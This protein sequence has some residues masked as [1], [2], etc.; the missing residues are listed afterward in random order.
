MQSTP[1]LEIDAWILDITVHHTGMLLWLKTRSGRTIRAIAPFK[2]SFYAV[3]H[4]YRSWKDKGKVNESYL[5]FIHSLKKNHLI[6]NV[7]IVSRR[8]KAEDVEES[9]VIQIMVDNPKNFKKVTKQVREMNSFTLYNADIPLAQMYLYE[10]ELFPMAFCRFKGKW[11]KNI[12]N[13]ESINLQDST[14]SIYYDLPQLKA[15]WI[16]IFS[17]SPHLERMHTDPIQEISISVDP[18]SQGIELSELFP[19]YVLNQSSSNQ[20]K[21]VL[22]EGNEYETLVSFS[23]AIEIIDPDFIFTARGDEYLF[24]YLLARLQAHHID[25]WFTLSRNKSPLRNSRF[26]KNGGNSFMSYGQILHRSNTEFYLT[27]RLHIDSAIYGGLHFDDGNL[28]GI[29]EVGRVTYSPLQR[30]TRVTIGGA[31]QSL[32]F[33]HAYRQGIL[34]AEEKKNAEYFRQGTNLFLSDRGGHILNPKIGMYDRVAELDFTSMYPALMVKYNVSPETINC[35][36]CTHAKIEIPGLNYHICQNRKGI[37]P[38]ALRVPLM[39]R[40]KYKQLSNVRDSRYA[41]RFQKMESA[42]KWILVVCFGYLG[43]RNARFGRIEAHQAVCAFSREFLLNAMRIVEKNGLDPIHGIVDSL[44]VQAPDGMLREDF[45]SRCKRSVQEIAQKT[46]IPINFS[47]NQ[48]YFDFICFLPTKED[49]EIGALNR[50]WGVKPDKR[51]KVRG[52]ELRRHDAPPFIKQFQKRLMQNIALSE[53][54]HDRSNLWTNAIV[55]L[56]LE[57]YWHLETGEV[58]LDDLLITIRLSKEL[59]EYKVKNYQ[60]ISASS[61]ER[62]GIKIGAGEKVSFL[63]VDDKA[64]NAEDRVCPVQLLNLSKISYDVS[65]YKELIVRALANILPNPLSDKQKKRLLTLS[66]KYPEIKTKIQK[67]LLAYL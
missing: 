59:S 5:P 18:C 63:I 50:Y 17:N 4:F 53:F 27:G 61:L 44:Y 11:A 60:A 29:I 51:M 13:L 41:H 67:T 35:P 15:V 64:K 49:P 26:E 24:P 23:Q 12:F 22:S 14:D 65:K 9:L 31:L 25:R 46:Q 8:I 6:S 7:S 2:P 52:I 32:Q 48:D 20:Q 10:T 30:L 43:F 19:P 62:H 56:L 34:I 66:P 21:I 45:F 54:R 16:D 3:H 1:Y 47:L 36:C 58:P 38:L 40:I 42:L 28:Y 57:Y 55:P 33:F 37:V 39:K